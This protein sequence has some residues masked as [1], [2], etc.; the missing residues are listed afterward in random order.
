MAAGL[1]DGSGGRDEQS[2]ALVAI[3]AYT[4]LCRLVGQLLAIPG[5]EGQHPLLLGQS[6]RS[7]LLGLDLCL[8]GGALLLGVAGALLAALVLAFGADLVGAVRGSAAVASAVDAHADGLLNTLDVDGKGRGGN[9]FVGLEGEAVFGKQS[10]G[11]LLL[12]GGTLHG[13]GGNDVLVVGV[14]LGDFYVGG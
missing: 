6:L 8:L 7:S 4:L 1:A 14:V 5:R 13:D 3:A 2:L 10:T 11:T 12:H 9:P